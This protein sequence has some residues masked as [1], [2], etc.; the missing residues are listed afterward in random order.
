M[1]R[2]DAHLFDGFVEDYDHFLDFSDPRVWDRLAEQGVTAG[3]RAVDLGC[4]T[5]R[6]CLEFADYFDEV[7]GVDL[8]KNMVDYATAKRPHRNV[9]YEARDLMEFE[10]DEGFDLVF[11]FT[12]LHHVPDLEAALHRLEHLA[13]PGGWVVLADC[14]AP[15][16]R[17]PGWTYRVSAVL[18]FPR[19][20]R[21]YGLREAV[22]LLRFRSVGPWYDHLETDRYLTEEEFDA[23]YGSVFEG[24]TFSSALGPRTMVWRSP[25]R[26]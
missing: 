7:V 25:A 13:R 20:L 16:A 6:R 18:H 12:T 8:S 17:V 5:G 24:A 26:T 19:D 21:Q 14:V 2:A 1:P 9:R 23:R 4:G 10:D 15:Q 22:W 11:S 3:E